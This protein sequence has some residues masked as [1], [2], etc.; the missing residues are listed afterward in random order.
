MKYFL[1]LITHSVINIL[2]RFFFVATISTAI[3]TIRVVVVRDLKIETCV[4][5]NFVI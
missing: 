4:D 3:S 5:N 1:L 2:K